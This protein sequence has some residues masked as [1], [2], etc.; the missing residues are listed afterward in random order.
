MRLAVISDIHGNLPALDAVLAD[1]DSRAVDAV[2]NLGDCVTGPLWPKET[3]A[4]LVAIDL[5]TVR[6]NHDRWIVDMPQDKLSAAGRHARDALSSS[7]RA[8]LH[9]LPAT[10]EVAP[11]ILAVHGTPTDDSTY[12][13]EDQV[14]GRLVPAA[15][16]TVAARLGDAARP[17]VVLCGHSH[18]QALVQGPGGAVV[19]NPGSVGCPAFADS[20]AAPTL[21]FRSPHAR[22]A[23]LTLRHGQWGAEMFAIDYD[24][25]AAARRAAENGRADWAAMLAT[26]AVG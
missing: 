9:A 17:G 18:R 26:G 14:D 15:R 11:E 22:Y 20:P 23:I 1:I 3:F 16:A 24:W 6:G 13:L 21:E 19:L 2:V 10:L 7:E 12:L 5:P 8:W 25:G 4:R